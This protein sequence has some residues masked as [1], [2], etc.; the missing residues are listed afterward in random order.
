MTKKSEKKS[1]EQDAKNTLHE[2]IKEK[3]VNHV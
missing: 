1:I 3:I 2:A